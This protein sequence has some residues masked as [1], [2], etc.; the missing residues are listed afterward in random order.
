MPV[1]RLST[2]GDVGP[3]AQVGSERDHARRVMPIVGDDRLNFVNRSSLI[4][5]CY[6]DE[7][8][9]E[10]RV[11]IRGVSHMEDRGHYDGGPQIECILDL[12]RHPCRA[13]FIHVIIASASC[14]FTHM[15]LETF[16]RR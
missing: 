15:S 5:S 11:H 12:V 1:L 14:R 4:G 8:S 9:V 6:H 16:L 3:P 7:C 2:L 13:V 10:N